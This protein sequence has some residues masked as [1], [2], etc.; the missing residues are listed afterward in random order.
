M[1][2]STRAHGF[3]VNH[4]VICKLFRISADLLRRRLNDFKQ[5]PSG[6]MLLY[7]YDDVDDDE[8]DHDEDDDDDDDDGYDDGYDDD[9]DDDDDWLEG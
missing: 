3:Q 7:Q 6:T 5:I 4:D 9:D 8:D 2:V 1:L